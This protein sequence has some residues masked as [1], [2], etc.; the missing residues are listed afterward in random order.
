MSDEK[1]FSLTT[2]KPVI[3]SY[4]HGEEPTPLHPSGIP[5]GFVTESPSPEIAYAFHPGGMILRYADGSEFNER[6]AK[7]ELKERDEIVTAA[8]T[9]DADAVAVVKTAYKA[10]KGSKTGGRS[11]KASKAALNAQAALEAAQPRTE[12]F[13]VEPGFDADAAVMNASE[14]SAVAAAEAESSLTN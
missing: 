10:V 11:R 8:E 3:V 4:P 9:G 12:A 14:Q 2:A 6:K 5:A 1:G 7:S 13:G